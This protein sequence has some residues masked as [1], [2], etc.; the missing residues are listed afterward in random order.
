MLLGIVLER[1]QRHLAAKELGE[2]GLVDLP[3]QRLVQA[4]VVHENELQMHCGKTVRRRGGYIWSIRNSSFSRQQVAI[5]VV[6]SWNRIQ[7]DL[8]ITLVL[9]LL[10]MNG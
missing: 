6:Y 7:R 3:A 4:L 9:V 2:L 1:D 8:S 10:S 5:G